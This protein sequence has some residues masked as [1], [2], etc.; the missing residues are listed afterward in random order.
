MVNYKS[1]TNGESLVALVSDRDVKEEIS[2][3]LEWIDEQIKHI[4]AEIAGEGEFNPEK[5][6]MEV[7]HIINGMQRIYQ[8]TDLEKDDDLFQGVVSTVNSFA[9]QEPQITDGLNGGIQRIAQGFGV[10]A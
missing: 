1:N 6:Q 8:N 10:H 9:A 5:V 7:A 4:E 3:D 2:N